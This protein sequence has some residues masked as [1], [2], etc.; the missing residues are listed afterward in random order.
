MGVYKLST[1]GGLAT[2]RTNYSS[3]LAG[4]PAYEIPTSYESIATVT[5]GSGGSSSIDFTSIPATYTH[6]QI[7]SIF[8]TDR[9]YPLDIPYVQ[10][11]NGSI[12]TGANY[13]WHR[14]YGNGSTAGADGDANQNYMYTLLSSASTGGADIFAAGI[15]DILDYANTNKYKTLRFFSGADLNGTPSSVPGQI[16]FTSGN[17][18]NTSAI[19]NIRITPVVGPNFVQYSQFALYGIKGA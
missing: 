11:G 8:R 16:H 14:L 10:V 13:S 12:D 15:I 7:R 6:L 9:S 18:R 19:T 3:F 1:A 4:N 17:W 5:V 2:P